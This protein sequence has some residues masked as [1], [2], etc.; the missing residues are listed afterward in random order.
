M[1]R[2]VPL[3]LHRNDP[4]LTFAA[5]AAK[6]G[7]W[8]LRMLDAARF[9]AEWSEDTSTKVGAVASNAAHAILTTGY[10][11]LPRGVRALPYRLSREPLRPGGRGAKYLYTAH[12]EE[13]LVA[14]AARAVLEGSTVTVTHFCCAGCARMLINAGVARIVVGDGKTSMPEEEFIAAQEMFVEAGVA[15]ERITCE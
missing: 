1:D 14:H 5:V 10:N 4:G 15:V 3:D 8:R 11:G 2:R 12:A 7:K 6:R 13:N 9:F